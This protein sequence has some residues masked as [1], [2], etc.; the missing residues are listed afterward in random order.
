MSRKMLTTMMQRGIVQSGLR[1]SRTLSSQ[2][3]SM[4]DYVCGLPFVRPALRQP[5][6]WPFARSPRGTASK[7]GC[8][9]DVRS[10]LRMRDG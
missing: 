1:L 3:S 8:A 9:A 2:S 10:T 5:C 6:S 7:R 4:L